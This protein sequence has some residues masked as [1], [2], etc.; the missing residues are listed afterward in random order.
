[1]V[2]GAT[3]AVGIMWSYFIPNCAFRISPNLGNFKYNMF[4]LENIFQT[5]S[6]SIL[7]YNFTRAN[8]IYFKIQG[9]DLQYTTNKVDQTAHNYLIILN[10]WNMYTF[11]SGKQRKTI[12]KLQLS[13]CLALL[14]QGV[15]S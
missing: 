5:Y 13:C 1:M 11:A 14:D 4:E 3:V 6:Q 7:H 12:I 10:C 15:A 8:N 2:A 9:F